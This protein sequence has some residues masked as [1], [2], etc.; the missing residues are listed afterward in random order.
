MDLTR[1]LAAVVASGSLDAAAAELQVTPSA[2]SQRLKTLESQLGRVLLV[3]SKP[4]QP[5]AAGQAFDGALDVS[6]GN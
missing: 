5:T 1:T 4:V 3:R 6:A 2:V